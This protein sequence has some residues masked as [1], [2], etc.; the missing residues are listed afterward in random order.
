MNG[1][2]HAWG[3]LFSWVPAPLQIGLA[4]VI[5]LLLVT[6]LLPRIIRTG[7]AAMRVAWEPGL[8]LLTYP[9]FLITAAT[10]RF[11]QAPIL[12]TYG[13]GRVLGALAEPGTKLGEWLASR[14]KGYRFP[15]KTALLIV[16]LLTTCWYLAP[17]VPPGG[18]RT[19]LSDVN[20]D[21]VHLNTWLTTGQWTHDT[22]PSACTGKLIKRPSHKKAKHHSKR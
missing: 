17:K 15:W 16:A 21:D 18:A 9:E 13:Y 3:S 1:I 6:K 8:E 5:V 4:L 12:G 19:V 7:G 2:R 14:R 10:R 11:G 22:P 20:T